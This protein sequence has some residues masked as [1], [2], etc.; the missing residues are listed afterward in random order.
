MNAWFCNVEHV[1]AKTY[2]ACVTKTHPGIEMIQLYVLVLTLVFGFVCFGPEWIHV[3]VVAPG[4]IKAHQVC[5][6]KTNPGIKCPYGV[7][8]FQCVIPCIGGIG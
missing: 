1:S 2:Q 3:F 5:T 4:S 8:R 6:K 7:Y